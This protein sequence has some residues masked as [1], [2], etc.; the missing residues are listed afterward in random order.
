MV[1]NRSGCISGLQIDGLYRSLKLLFGLQSK[2]ESRNAAQVFLHW[3]R[4]DKSQQ[5]MRAEIVTREY[6][7]SASWVYKIERE[8]KIGG[9]KKKNRNTGKVEGMEIWHFN[10]HIERTRLK[11]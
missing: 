3:G 7:I 5:S 8:V 6:Q 9:K 1:R 11:N 4:C 10:E 2:K